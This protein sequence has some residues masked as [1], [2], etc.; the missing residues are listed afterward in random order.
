MKPLELSCI[1]GVWKSALNILNQ[2]LSGIGDDLQ[3]WFPWG[4]TWRGQ[5]A[6]GSLPPTNF[7]DDIVSEDVSRF[8]GRLWKAVSLG[9]VT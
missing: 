8:G 6:N 5:D 9:G 2:S 3:L 1:T 4:R 7:P